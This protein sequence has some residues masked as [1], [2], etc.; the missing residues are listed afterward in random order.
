MLGA[1]IGH[2]VGDYLLQNDW[3]AQNKKKD[4]LVCLGHCL[5]WAYCVVLFG[6][7][8]CDGWIVWPGI[9]VFPILVATHFI[10]NRTMIVPRLMGVIGQ[11]QFR[12]GPCAPWSLIV[13]DNVWHIVTI[14]W[15]WKAFDL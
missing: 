12:D 15:I 2:L 11:Q 1:I 13:V 8:Y 14:F 7:L 3:M 10:Q 9:V 5:I 6:D 4:S